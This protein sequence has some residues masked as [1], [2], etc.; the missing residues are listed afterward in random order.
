[1]TSIT[2]DKKLQGE[3]VIASFV[4]ALPRKPGV[5]R[6]LDENDN[7]LYVGKAKDLRKRVTSYTKITGHSLRIAR[8]I[9]S[10]KDMVFVTTETELEALLLEQNLIKKFQPQYNVL[11]KD[12]KSFPQISITKNKKFPQVIKFRGRKIE[13][14][15]YFGPYAS[16]SAVD[17]AVNY[18]QK[19]FQL[20][21]C[22]DSIFFSRT[23][24]CLLHFIHKCSAPCVGKISEYEYERA[25]EQAENFL[26]GKH[27]AIKDNLKDNMLRSSKEMDFERAAFYRDRIELIAKIQSSQNINNLNLKDADVVGIYK[28]GNDSCIQIFFIRSYENRGNHAF[29]PRTGK[30]ADKVEILEHFLAQFYGNKV[31]AKQV[32][33]SQALPNKNLIREFLIEKK[34]GNV[35]IKCPLKGRSKDLI[36]AVEANAKEALERKLA[37]SASQSALF[38]SI[39]K[40][41]DLSRKITKIEVYDNSHIQGNFPV[42]CLISLDQNGYRKSEYRKFNL[43]DENVNPGD[44]L[45]IMQHVLERRFKKTA[46]LINAKEERDLPDLIIMDGGKNQLNIA[47]KVLHQLDIREIPIISI[48]K[49]IKRNSGNEQFY[50]KDKI[51]S[52]PKN[53]SILFFFQRI[54]DEA[55]RFAIRTHRKKRLSSVNRSELDN[56]FGIGPKKKKEL[57]QHFGSVREI[58]K[59]SA[60][61]LLKVKGIS[62]SSAQIIFNHFNS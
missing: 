10:T 41:L 61:D 50:F 31:P 53:S 24:A 43:K 48:A 55:H 38:K 37:M 11:L 8:M 22:R 2:V 44:D 30:G 14:D 51:I 29:F 6:M 26:Q 1:V 28:I 36:R 19:I 23:R 33:I 21:N 18:I 3:K 47:T 7:V 60:K 56:V 13:G 58:A 54:R 15:K 49:G 59:S 20:R 40:E 32:L 34:N 35:E 42:G 27:S 46:R 4:I 16:S 45:G 62:T 57:L 17:N 25:V 12:D 9:S 39:E 5:Y 52:F